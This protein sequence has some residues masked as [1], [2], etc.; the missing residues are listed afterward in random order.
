VS[1]RVTLTDLQRLSKVFDEAK[2]CAA[3]LRQL[4]F[5]LEPSSSCTWRVTLQLTV[6]EIFA[7][8]QGQNFRFLGPLGYRPKK[9][10]TSPGPICII[11]QI[12]TPIGAGYLSPN[13]N[14]YFPMLYI[15]PSSCYWHV[16]LRLIACDVH[17]LEGQNFGFWGSLSVPPSKGSKPIQQPYLYHRVNFDTN[18]C[19]CHRYTCNQKTGQRIL[20]FGDPLGVLLTKEEKTSSGQMCIVVQIFRPIRARYHCCR[21]RSKPGCR[22][23]GLHTRWEL[24]T[25][26]RLPVMPPSTFDV[27]WLQVQPQR[28]PGSMSVVAMVG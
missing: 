22:I 19:H 13:K 9:E 23:V 21:G 11:M 10:K 15:L 2:Q 6:F 26:S 25:L 27:N 14:T 3:S 12:F 16:T 4:S 24:T 28:L 17:F 18:R 20:D 7:F 1:F 5:L 8:L